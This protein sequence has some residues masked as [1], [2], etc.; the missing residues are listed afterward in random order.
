MGSLF[1]GLLSQRHEVVLVGRKAHMAA[2][3][4]HGLSISGR[5]QMVAHP[6]AREDLSSLESIDVILITVKAYDTEKAVIALKPFWRSALFLSLQN[7]LGNEEL[8][9]R[10]ADRVLGGVTGQGV[11]FMAPG[12]VYHA[13]VGDTYIGPYQGVAP[14]ETAQVIEA[15][16]SCDIPCSLSDDIRRD[17]WMKALV[18]ACINPLT[19][20]LRVRNGHL[21]GSEVL[22]ELMR[23]IAEEGV[24]VASAY[25]LQ[26]N[27]QEVLQRV[28]TVAEATAENRSSMLQDLERGRKTEIDSINGAIVELGREKGVECRVNSLLTL[29]VK[30]IEEASP[31]K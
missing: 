6:T 14:T 5:T 1:G 22:S 7:G 18:N 11:T 2:I 23:D 16:R 13:G 24:R 19:G 15:F 3:R 17:L 12:E 25:G 29:L 21:L 9:A 10:R 26:L 8:L 30:A 4:Q 31:A 20:T 27:H 28:R